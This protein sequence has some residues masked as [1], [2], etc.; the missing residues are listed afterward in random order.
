MLI[1]YTEHG[2]EVNY[3]ILNRNFIKFNLLKTICM[4]FLLLLL[5]F[6]LIR[7]ALYHYFMTWKY[8]VILVLIYGSCELIHNNKMHI[9]FYSIGFKNKDIG[10]KYREIEVN[11]E[12]I[13]FITNIKKRFFRWNTIIRIKNKKRN[14]H[15]ILKD[16]REIRI[17]KIIFTDKN[18]IKEFLTQIKNNIHNTAYK[19]K[20]KEYETYCNYSIGKKEISYL[21]N[22]FQTSKKYFREFLIISTVIVSIFILFR[23]YMLNKL[24]DFQLAWMYSTTREMENLL[25]GISIFIPIIYVLIYNILANKIFLKHILKNALLISI[26]GNHSLKFTSEGIFLNDD[27]QEEFYF[28]EAVKYLYISKERGLVYLTTRVKDE[29]MV[30]SE[31]ILAIIPLKFIKPTISIDDFT[32]KIIQHAPHLEIDNRK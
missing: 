30:F 7:L 14:I 9:K 25:T 27:I 17:S 15:I 28:W 24:S 22:S 23:I 2:K 13:Y 29:E 1:K 12:G 8:Y 21:C 31:N 4:T 19:V 10:E 6:T 16:Q 5:F 20:A 26:K 11:K 3:S 32:Q 18:E